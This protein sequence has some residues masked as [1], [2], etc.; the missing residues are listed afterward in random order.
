M[1]F[2]ELA[3]LLLSNLLHD[4]CSTGTWGLFCSEFLP[5]L[6]GLSGTPFSWLSPG[7][8]ASG[9]RAL[10]AYVGKLAASVCWMGAHPD[11]LVAPVCRPTL[12]FQTNAYIPAC[13]CQIADAPL[14]QMRGAPFEYLPFART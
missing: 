13:A 1:G 14:S 11:T 4:L 3:L 10:A 6:A 9:T 8:L 5:A 7:G 12:V 2:S